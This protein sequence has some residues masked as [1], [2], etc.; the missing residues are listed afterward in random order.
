[1]QDAT[2]SEQQVY[3]CHAAHDEFINNSCCVVTERVVDDR[4]DKGQKR[5]GAKEGVA[6]MPAREED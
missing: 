6:R 3:N 2:R 1:M 4:H 5:A